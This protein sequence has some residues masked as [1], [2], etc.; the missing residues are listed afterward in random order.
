MSMY[1]GS[2]KPKDTFNTLYT[3][4]IN[5]LLIFFIFIFTSV[6]IK[7]FLYVW[8]HYEAFP[9]LFHPTC[10]LW[11]EAKHCRTTRRGCRHVIVHPRGL[12]L[13]SYES[14]CEQTDVSKMLLDFL[15]CSLLDLVLETG[16]SM[17]SEVIFLWLCLCILMMCLFAGSK[18]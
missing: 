18:T 15:N 2:T 10:L 7:I 11:T 3:V 16:E 5:T 4:F 9:A 8:V 12:F 1:K 6:G 14:Y 13:C 17:G